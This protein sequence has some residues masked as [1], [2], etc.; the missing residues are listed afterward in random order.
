VIRYAHLRRAGPELEAERYAD[1]R[2]HPRGDRGL[3]GRAA[4][5]RG[6]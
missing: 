1:T 3:S 6:N 4:R 2:N 5:S